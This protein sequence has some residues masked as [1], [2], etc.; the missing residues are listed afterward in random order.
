MER[1]KTAVSRALRPILAAFVVVSL[2][3]ASPEVRGAPPGDELAQAL[4]D[5]VVSIIAEWQNGETHDG[6]GFIAGERD[7]QLYIVTANHVVRGALPDEIATTMDIEFYDRQ[8]QKFP[9][10]LLATS[11]KSHDLAVLR[12]PLPQGLPWTKDVFSDEGAER[13]MS[14]WFVGR[15]GGWYVPSTPGTINAIGLDDKIAIDDLNVRVGTS[16]A[17]LIADSGIVG[18]VVSEESGITYAVSIEF[19]KK[20][21]GYWN[22]PWQLTARPPTAVG[23]PPE[24]EVTIIPIEAMYVTIKIAN[25]REEPTVKSAKVTTLKRGAEVYVAGKVEDKNWYLVE[26]DDRTLGYVFGELLRDAETARQ[27]EEE[28]VRAEAEAR[29]QE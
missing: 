24:V 15:A 6:F 26:R 18:M 16:G 5:N 9:G 23:E 7:G 1:A 14:V 19:I 25:V 20:A 17:P 13:L 3:A 21:F 11:D 10:T 2:N 28:R 29:K 27:E 8:G 4:R 22:H 12:V